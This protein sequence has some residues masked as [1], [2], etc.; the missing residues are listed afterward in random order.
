MAR[1]GF[2]DS[3]PN[4]HQRRRNRA[5]RA[6]SWTFQ[7][8][9]SSLFGFALALSSTA[10]AVKIL[11][12]IGELRNRSGRV[13]IG[14]LIAQDLAVAPML[15]FVTSF[16]GD[17]FNPIVLV[18]VAASIGV[19]V[20]VIMFMSRRQR[21][22]LPFHRIL[23]A[24]KEIGTM[25]SLAL[26]FVF[27]TMAGL[28]GLSPAFGAFLAGLIV[29]NSGQRQV[30]HENAEPVQAVLLMV[31]FLSIG[32]LINLEF[33]AEN[34]VLVLAVWHLRDLLQDGH[35]HRRPAPVQGETMQTAFLASLTIG[36]MGEFTFVLAGAASNAR[37]ID[38]EIYRL[39]VA[40]TVLSLMTSP[41]YVDLAR[42]LSH[43]SVRNVTTLRNAFRL[44]YRREWRFTK[45]TSLWFWHIAHDAIEGF[46]NMTSEAKSKARSRI[47]A[48][49]LAK[50]AEQSN[51]NGPS[52]NS[53]EDPP[54]PEPEEPLQSPEGESPAENKQPPRFSRSKKKTPPP[55]DD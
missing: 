4:R 45:A 18:E 40:V 12:D 21:V 27:A 54:W 48:I 17:G 5:D 50:N 36:Q 6:D 29:G 11:D 39:L 14:I 16:A 19:L 7:H 3:I 28:F 2:H 52:H 37:V 43:R 26:C 47:E 1:G 23:E 15:L 30:M 25:G 49:K 20:A 34:I 42:R 33:I 41:V 51:K 32:L 10:V 55:S 46:E 13:A 31:F 9:I 8:P 44:I 24:K 22:N 53:A 35:Q 38:E